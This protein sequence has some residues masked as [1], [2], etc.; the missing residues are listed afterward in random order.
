[1]KA[2][3]VAGIFLAGMACSD[4]ASVVERQSE[5]YGESQVAAEMID[6]LTVGEVWASSETGSWSVL[7]TSAEGRTCLVRA[8]GGWF[9]VPTPASIR[10]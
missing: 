4:R 5:K 2:T 9:D 3:L 1:M 10:I 6:P 7:V 8:G